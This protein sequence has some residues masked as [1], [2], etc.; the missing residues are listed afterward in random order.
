MTLVGKGVCFDTGG[1]DLK[2]SSGM[3]LMK[4]DMGGA[5]TMLG[6]AHAVMAAKLRCGCACWCRRWRIPSRATP[7]GPLDIVKT[8]KG[9]TVEIG[10]TD[11]EG[12]LILCDALAEA[13][14]ENPALLLDLAT[15]TGAARVALGPDLPALFA[16][17][18][19]LAD[20]LLRAGTAEARSA[21][22]LAAVAGL[23]RHAAKAR[24]PTSTMFR[25]RRSPARSQA[26]LYLAGVRPGEDAWAHVDTFAWNPQ[27]A[28]RPA[29]RRRGA[30][31]ARALRA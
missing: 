26:A 2:P 30:G 14:S 1:L 3:R 25:N 12:R 4:K 17:D 10:N 11:A 23:S 5:A 27:Y 31:P 15:L 8:R 6:L 18:D 20:D 22:A 21:V 19:A 9:I 16:N 28:A 13:D 24:S 7:S 29:R